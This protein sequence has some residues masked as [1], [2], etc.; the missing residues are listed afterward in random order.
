VALYCLQDK[1][2]F[3]LSQHTDKRTW[4]LPGSCHHAAFLAHY[5]LIPWKTD[6][7][8]RRFTF[9]RNGTCTWKFQTC[10]GGKYSAQINAD[11]SAPWLLLTV[12]VAFFN[13]FQRKTCLFIRTLFGRTSNAVTQ[14]GPTPSH[15]TFS[16]LQVFNCYQTKTSTRKVHSIAKFKKQFETISGHKPDTLCESSFRIPQNRSI[17]S[18][19][20]PEP[21]AFQCRQAADAVKRLRVSRGRR[22]VAT[23]RERERNLPW[24]SNGLWIPARKCVLIRRHYGI[25]YD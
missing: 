18:E 2:S 8:K 17:F 9:A 5:T 23:R 14:R 11:R 13:S 3:I 20:R 15:V 24:R 21:V 10:F 16:S 7:T 12:Y 25:V 4:T 1:L 19:T 6:P 22:P